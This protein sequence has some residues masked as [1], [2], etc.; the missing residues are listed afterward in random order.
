VIGSK[1]NN[2]QISNEL[3]YSPSIAKT[4]WLSHGERP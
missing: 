4:M 3:Y 2:P 1:K